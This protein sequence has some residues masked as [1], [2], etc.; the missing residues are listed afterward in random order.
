MTLTDDEVAL[1]LLVLDGLQDIRSP[2]MCP[3]QMAE[4]SLAIANC[5]GLDALHCKLKT[6]NKDACS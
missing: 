2:A 3:M 1:L 5:P 4:A 6:T